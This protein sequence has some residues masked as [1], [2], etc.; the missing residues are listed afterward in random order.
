M[1]RR[2]VKRYEPLSQDR[3]RRWVL[4]VGRQTS[5]RHRVIVQ[6]PQ[7][8]VTRTAEKPAHQAVGVPV[9]DRKSPGRARRPRAPEAHAA[10]AFL[11]CIVLLRRQAVGFGDVRRVP[12]ELSGA[13]H[14]TVAGCAPRPGL[15]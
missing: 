13:E 10:L 6:M 8:G 12:G 2:P 3:D 14:L 15:R 7:E 5:Q 11:D 1:R 9:V 4:E